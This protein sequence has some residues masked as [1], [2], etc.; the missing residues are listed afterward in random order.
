MSPVTASV[1]GRR[2]A[3]VG[4]NPDLLPELHHGVTWPG[5][6]QNTTNPSPQEA[7]VYFYDPYPAPLHD[8][9]LPVNG[10]TTP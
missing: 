4:P 8:A 5:A 10:D 2:T 7:P 9:L 3:G 6:G 1:G